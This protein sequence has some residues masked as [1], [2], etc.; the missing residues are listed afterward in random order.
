MKEYILYCFEGSKLLRC[1][2]FSAPD[3]HAAI[4]EAIARHDG[5]A[6][7]LWRGSRKVKVFE[8]PP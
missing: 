7:E 3:D 4:E 8:K 6:A 1:D 5:A 2:S